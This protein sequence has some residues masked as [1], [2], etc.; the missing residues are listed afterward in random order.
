MTAR[1]ASFAEVF[2]STSARIDISASSATL[3]C[4]L[5]RL[6]VLEE[7]RRLQEV[8]DARFRVPVLRKRP[9]DAVAGALPTSPVE[10]GA[11]VALD[12]GVV[13]EGKRVLALSCV[14]HAGLP[15]GG[16]GGGFGG[17]WWGGGWFC[18]Y[19]G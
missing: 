12:F 17:V 10:Q 19:R 16:G 15:G 2:E 7:Q 8:R 6:G 13:R 11:L 4:P 5:R 1:P 3:E 14:A 9:N 18:R